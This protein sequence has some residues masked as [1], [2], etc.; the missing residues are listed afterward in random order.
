MKSHIDNELVNIAFSSERYNTLSDKEKERVYKEIINAVLQKADSKILDLY[1]KKE[2]VSNEVNSLLLWVI[3]LNDDDKPVKPQT[4]KSIGSY[5]DID[6]DFSQEKRGEV[7]NYLIDKYGSN[8]VT[9][10][11]TFGTLKARLAV[12]AAANALYY[13]VQDK[14]KVSKHIPED[15]GLKLKE[16]IE[17][18]DVLSKI[19]ESDKE[20]DKKSKEILSVALELENLINNIGSHASAC[21]IT[22]GDLVDHIP[23]MVSTQKLGK[24]VLSQYEFHDVEAL[25][26]LKFDLLGLS[27]LDVIHKTVALIKE[28]YGI[29]IDI[30]N[31]DDSDPSIYKLLNSGNVDSIFQLDGSAGAY[32]T[33]LKPVSIEEIS[34][35]TSLIRPGPMSMGMMDQYIKA[36]FNNEKYQYNLKDQNLI[37]KVWDICKSSYGLMVYQENVIKCFT[38]ISGFNEIEG[39][40]ARRAMGKLS[41]PIS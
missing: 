4:I 36:K 30:D 6:I 22:N 10:I 33:K 35:L 26:C 23:L 15:P 7:I 18:S 17:K 14:E 8:R 28:N 13:T 19:M 3:G 29:E 25:G 27:T 1:H 2:K 34:D 31:L 32:I 24:K 21:V 41:C 20:E 11:A 12:L 5:C 9:S 38:D 16:A 39:D 40:N 37:S